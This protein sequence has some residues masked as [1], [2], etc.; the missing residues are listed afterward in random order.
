MAY[1]SNGTEGAI[2]DVQCMKCRHFEKPCPISTIQEL[3]NYDQIKL[4]NAGYPQLME[5]MNILI[6]EE[7]E[8]QMYEEETNE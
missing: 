4:E 7:G 8:C 6:N 2:L 5:A 1:F 3:Y